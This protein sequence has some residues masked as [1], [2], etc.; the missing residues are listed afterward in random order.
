MTG[1]NKAIVGSKKFESHN[2]SRIY[3]PYISPVWLF[4]DARFFSTNFRPIDLLHPFSRHEHLVKLEIVW[5]VVEIIQYVSQDCW[6]CSQFRLSP[7]HVHNTDLA[8]G[9]HATLHDW[10]ASGNTNAQYQY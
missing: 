4:M 8:G 6:R 5:L 1:Y 3:S 7:A 10:D 2:P 9:S